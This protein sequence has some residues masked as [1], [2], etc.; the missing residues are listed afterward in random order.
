VGGVS[1]R[2]WAGGCARSEAFGSEADSGLAKARH[3]V[4]TERPLPVQTGEMPVP[5][6]LVQVET[7]GLVQAETSG[8]FRGR[9]VYTV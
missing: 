5:H 4:E 3:L 7:S 8:L 6:C 2:G 9:I 1:G